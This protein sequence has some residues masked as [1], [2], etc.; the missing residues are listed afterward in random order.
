MLSAVLFLL[1]SN[2]FLLLT[3]G[4][5]LAKPFPGDDFLGEADFLK[6]D[7]LTDPRS[8]GCFKRSV[9]VFFPESFYSLLVPDSKL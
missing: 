9:L 8:L 7:L 3:P 1:P 5:F 6:P 2:L 4:L